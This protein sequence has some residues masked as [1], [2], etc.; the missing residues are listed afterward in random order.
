MKTYKVDFE[1]NAISGDQLAL[2]IQHID[3]SVIIKK[4]AEIKII[5]SGK[6]NIYYL[7]V[8]DSGIEIKIEVTGTLLNTVIGIKEL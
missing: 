6:Q 8:C 3:G 2:P 4:D 1:K 5:D 7:V